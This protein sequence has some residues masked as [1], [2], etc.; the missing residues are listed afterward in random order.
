MRPLRVKASSTPITSSNFQGLQ[1]MT[2]SEINQYLS[3]VITNKFATDTDGTGTAEL[4]VDTANALAGTSIGTFTDTIRDDAIGDHPTDGATSSTTYYFKQVTSAATENITNRLVG[5]DSAI[6]EMTDADLDTDILDKVV[7][8][9]INETDY[10]VGQYTLAASAP[11]GGTWTSRY[12]ITDSAQGG[13]TQIYL[14]QKTSPT[15]SANSDFTS[16][17]L[18]G[19]SATRMMTAAEIEQMLN[20]ADMAF[21]VAGMGGGT[22]TGSAPVIARISKSKK[23]LTV[24]VVTLPFSFEGKRRMRAALQGVATLR[25]NT[26][27]L[28]VIPNERLLEATDRSTSF[29][30]AFHMVD[31]VLVHAIQGITD[32]L[33]GVG[34]INVDFADMQTVMEGMGR[35]VI[36]SGTGVGK[37]RMFR[38]IDSAIH[39]PLMQ[40]T[41][42]QGAKGILIHLVAP[43]DAGAL[44]I[45]AAMNQLEDLADDDV[46]LI[47]GA[48]LTDT[49]EDQVSVTVIATGLPE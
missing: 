35:A 14:W 20:G 19:T 13:N 29:K 3:Y 30:D 33:N 18:S 32:L 1:E 28:L 31:E 21:I 8:D 22:G 40:D 34:D 26:D 12:T 10:T 42:I 46:N 47:W 5:Y 4:N 41:D 7:L 23:I 27:T 45:T 15:S 36:G 2:N 6:K 38:A 37:D 43:R 48:T 24:G 49:P 44:E 16:L 9:M 25:E 17:K 11:T 39:S